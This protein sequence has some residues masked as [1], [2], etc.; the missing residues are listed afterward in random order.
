MRNL[1]GLSIPRIEDEP[2]VRGAGCF[3]DD[4]HVPGLLHASFV[5]SPHA[6]AA[7]TG[8][9]TQAASAM[10]GIHAILVLD[11]LVAVLRHRRM[12]RHSNSGTALDLIW[13]FALADREVSY[14]GE[15]VAIVIGDNRYVTEDAAALVQVDYN[16]LDAVVDCRSSEGA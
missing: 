1:I 11:D 14:V 15:P 12:K 16:V 8:I 7:I 3:I 5:R 4:I 13:P 10:L 9:D 6:H 2:L